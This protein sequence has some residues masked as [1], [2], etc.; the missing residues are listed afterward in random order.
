M[1]SNRGIWSDRSSNLPSGCMNAGLVLKTLVCRSVSFFTFV[2]TSPNSEVD[3]GPMDSAAP[4][5]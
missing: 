2:P 5:A 3:L 1:L 4:L